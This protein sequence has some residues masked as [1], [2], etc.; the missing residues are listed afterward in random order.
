MVTE[1]LIEAAMGIHVQAE[2]LALCIFNI[3]LNAH[4]VSCL[5]SPAACAGFQVLHIPAA[6]CSCHCLM[7]CLA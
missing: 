6:T 5:K 4:N 1:L 3:V 2:P 7:R